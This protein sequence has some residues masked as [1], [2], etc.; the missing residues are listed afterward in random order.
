[1]YR[2]RKND[3]IEDRALLV[4]EF[5]DIIRPGGPYRKAAHRATFLI[6]SAHAEYDYRIRDAISRAL[7]FRFAAHC[8]DGH[9]DA[10]I[11]NRATE[12]AK[13]AETVVDRALV[14][15][16][17]EKKDRLIVL[18]AIRAAAFRYYCAELDKLRRFAK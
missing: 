16:G 7:L 1:M 14:I 4:G 18:R 5:A 17:L 3:A 15:C 12:D 11:R 6:V 13:N 9:S 2:Q 10:L 8:F